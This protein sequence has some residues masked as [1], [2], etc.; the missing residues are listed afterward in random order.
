MTNIHAQALGKI[1]GA[2]GTGKSKVRG[3][4]SYYQWLAKLSAN[5]RKSNKSKKASK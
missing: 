4:R 3:D 1:G 5:K 2:A